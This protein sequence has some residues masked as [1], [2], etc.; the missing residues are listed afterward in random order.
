MRAVLTAVSKALSVDEGA[1]TLQRVS[2]SPHSN[3]GVADM[4]D[5]AKL[6]WTK[7]WWSEGSYRGRICH[8]H[9]STPSK[10]PGYARRAIHQCTHSPKF[11]EPGCE[12][13]KKRG[14]RFL[15]AN[16]FLMVS[17]SWVTPIGTCNQVL[18][19][20]KNMFI[21]DY[22]CRSHLRNFL[23]CSSGVSQ[24]VSCSS[25]ETCQGAKPTFIFF[26]LHRR[27]VK[28]NGIPSLACAGVGGNPLFQPRM[29]LPIPRVILGRRKIF[30][31]VW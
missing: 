11:L 31:S 27:W 14:E 29:W 10:W 28:K 15:M 21:G 18:W 6:D 1:N 7:P 13:F 22:H 25:E 5:T 26:H 3:R 12:T 17:L 16:P 20:K 30:L 9:Q 8:N 2:A 24:N 4:S 19:S 23:S